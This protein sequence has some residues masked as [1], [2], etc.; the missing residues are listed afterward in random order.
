MKFA[1]V[2]TVVVERAQHM[3]LQM[4]HAMQPII[5]RIHLH[6]M[7]RQW[8]RT[9][10]RRSRMKKRR[11]RIPTVFAG[12][13]AMNSVA[14][15][16]CRAYRGHRTQRGRKPAVAVRLVATQRNIGYTKRIACLGHTQ[17]RRC[18]CLGHSRVPSRARELRPWSC[19][20]EGMFIY[21]AWLHKTTLEE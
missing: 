3:P 17:V 7:R 15:Q 5:A 19:Q 1:H 12:I 6:C 11:S 13:M 8:R 2:R 21:P 4:A 20:I 10:Q 16:S 9:G 14:G 18:F